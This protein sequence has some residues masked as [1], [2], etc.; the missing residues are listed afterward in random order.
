MNARRPA[1]TPWRDNVEA[2]TV[3]I[4]MAVMLKYFI[5]EAYKIPTGSMQPTLFGQAWDSDQ[6]GTADGGVFDR[7]LVDKLSYRFRDPERFEV[8]VFKY[9]LDRAKH[10][11]KRLVG[12]PGEELRIQRGDLWTRPDDRSPWTILRRPAHVMRDVWKRMDLALDSG[13]PLWKPEG[14][15]A[16]GWSFEGRRIEAGSA[17]GAS[18]VGHG[19]ADPGGAITDTYVHGYPKAIRGHIRDAKPPLVVGDLRV[20]GSVRPA[21]GCARFTLAID[22]GPLQHRFVFPGP[23][24][25]AGERVRVESSP[26]SSDPG[27]ASGSAVSELGPLAADRSVAFAVQNLDDRLALYLGGELACELEVPSVDLNPGEYP[28]TNGGGRKRTAIRL[29]LTGGG[30]LLDDLACYRDIYYKPAMDGTSQ[31][32]IPPGHYFMLGDN[33][34]DSS[35]SREWAWYTLAW[36]GPGS[37]GAPVR[38]NRR[39]PLGRSPREV[40]HDANPIEAPTDEGLITFFRDEWGERYAFPSSAR[41]SVPGGSG[42]RAPFVARELI[43]GR[44]LLVFWPIAPWKGITRLKWVD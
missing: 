37:E 17:G 25:P 1:S 24:A 3:A 10:F 31:W 27:L 8:V 41:R 20:T 34:Q 29:E 28:S 32:T 2:M 30:A 22:E 6:N 43:A 26:L 33:T 18:Y 42:E 9:P 11:V 19:G 38:G 16:G 40:P 35:D 23:A 39:I 21:A 13:L 7:I 36:D 44:A 5:V 14:E 12:M 15:A 4:V